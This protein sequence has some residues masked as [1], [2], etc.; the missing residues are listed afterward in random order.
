MGL[1]TSLWKWNDLIRFQLN[2]A[3]RWL[4]RGR[5]SK[6]KFAKFFFHFSGFNAL[7]Y[8]WTEVDDLKNEMGRRP[9]EP[10]QI[11]NLLRKFDK[12]EASE[13]L[14]ILSEDV[15]YFCERNPIGRM[16]KRDPTNPSDGDPEEGKKWQRW[17]KEREDSVDKVVALGEILYI[18]RSNLFHGSKGESGDDEK[19][20]NHSTTPLE[21]LIT[22]VLAMTGS[23]CPWER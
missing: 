16:D 13:I 2:I 11:E 21:I 22:E 1:D 20:I 8:L 5:K 4:K 18:V 3:E 12:E 10:K 17:L 19:I 14:K 23:K 7:Y 6:D 9:N 15:K